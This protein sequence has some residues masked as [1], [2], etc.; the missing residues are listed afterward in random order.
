MR[1]RVAAVVVCVCV[2]VYGRGCVGGGMFS[3]LKHSSLVAVTR[4]FGGSILCAAH[5]CSTVDAV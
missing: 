4:V 2:C 1:G 3:H 5:G